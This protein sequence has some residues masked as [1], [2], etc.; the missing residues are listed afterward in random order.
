MK[1]IITICCAAAFSLAIGAPASANVIFSD[2]FNRANSG[3]VGNG[4]V[5]TGLGGSIVSNQLDISGNGTGSVTQGTMVLSTIGLTNILLDY[6]WQGVNTEAGDRLQVFWSADGSIFNLFATH[7]LATTSLTH[8]SVALTGAAGLADISIRFTF[9]GDMGNDASRIDNVSLQGDATPVP[10][11]EPTTLG[12]L[13]LG[14]LG[15]CAMKRRLRKVS[16]T[17]H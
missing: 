9:T 1:P 8:N 16:K 10:V 6:D 13:G 4:W 11:P 2:N 12:L 3:T 7:D 5:E 17:R 14:L 15:A